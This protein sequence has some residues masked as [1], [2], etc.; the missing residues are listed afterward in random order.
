M[1]PAWTDFVEDKDVRATERRTQMPPP[2]D[3]RACFYFCQELIQLMEAVYH[4]LRLERAW[5]H[6]DNR[7]WMNMFRHWSWAPIFRIAWAVGAPTFGRSFVS[8][9]ELRLDMPRL[10]DVVRAEEDSPGNIGWPAHCDALAGDGRVNH[11]ERSILVSEP[12]TRESCAEKLRIFLMKLDWKAV[13]QSGDEGRP[14]DTTC[15]VAVLCGNTLRMLRV[16]DHLRQMGLGLAFMRSVAA[17]ARD[18]EVDVPSG[19]YGLVGNVTPEQAE[20]IGDALRS[21][22]ARARAI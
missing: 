1:Y 10:S 19:D 17:V 9:C 16:Q 22:L 21:L 5:N 14:D 2:D 20:S 7:G 15:G 18:I 11:V 3:F 4:D 6:P 12:I 13:V 8:F